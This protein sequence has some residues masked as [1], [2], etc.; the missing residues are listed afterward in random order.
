V[1]EV[2]LVVLNEAWCHRKFAERDLDALETGES[3]S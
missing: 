2:L 1:R 3:M